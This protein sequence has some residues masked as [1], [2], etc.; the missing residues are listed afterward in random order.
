MLRIS[1]PACSCGLVELGW[2]DEDARLGPIGRRLSSQQ[3]RGHDVLAVRRIPGGE[4]YVACRLAPGLQLVAKP[5]S[6]A[7]AGQLVGRDLFE[8]FVC[9]QEEPSRGSV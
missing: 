9:E 1:R 5:W 8:L 7:G 3:V 6:G 4:E 2:T